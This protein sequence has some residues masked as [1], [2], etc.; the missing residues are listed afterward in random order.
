MESQKRTVRFYGVLTHDDFNGSVKDIIN[1]LQSV[2]NEHGPDATLDTIIED[3]YLDVC[4]FRPETDEEVEIRVAKEKAAKEDLFVNEQAK[5]QALAKLTAEEIK[6]LKIL[7][8]S[9]L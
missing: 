3:E 4:L 8:N 2:L 5:R 1:K 7:K 9:L 6:L